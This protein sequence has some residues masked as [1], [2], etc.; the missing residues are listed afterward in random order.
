MDPEAIV[1]SFVAAWNRM[2]FE[3]IIEMLDQDVLYHNIPMKPLHGRDAVRAYLH[4]AWRFETVDWKIVN[5]ASNGNV[6]LTERVDD[7]V[8]N[9]HQISLPIMGAFEVADHK[10]KAWRDYFDLAGYR[11]QLATAVADS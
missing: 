1:E 3:A 5:I 11:A 9:G 10:I 4:D 8:I 2:D 6:V 7:M